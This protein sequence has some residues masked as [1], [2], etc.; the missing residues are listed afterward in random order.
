MTDVLIY[1]EI[2][3]EV[4]ASGV[5]DQLK[6]AA[7]EPVTVRISSGG[8]DVYEGIAIMNALRGYEGAV[9]VVIESLAASAASFIAAGCGGRVVARPNAE[10]MVHRA[11]TMQMGNSDDL[12]KTIGDLERQDTKLAAIYADKSGGGAE[13]WLDRMAAETWFT[14]QEAMDAGLV[15]AV[16]DAKPMAPA[17][18]MQK[19][20][21]LASC[22]YGS[23]SAAPPPPI[24]PRSESRSTI[25]TTPSDGQNGA[26]MSILN[27]LAQDLG[28][29]PAEVQSALAGLFRNEVVPISGEVNVTYPAD[30]KIIPTQTIKIEPIVGDKPAEGADGSVEVVPEGEA[31]AEPAGDSAAVQLAKSAGLAFAMGDIAEGWTAEVDEGGI[32]TVKAPSGAEV[33]ASADFTVLVNETSVALAVT[34]RSFDEDTPPAPDENPAPPAAPADT[35]AAVADTVTVP[36]AHFDYLNSVVKNFGQAQAKLTAQENAQRVDRDIAEGRFVAAHRAQA[37]SALEHSP[38][39]Y[40]KVWGSLPKNTIP[41]A[42]IGS[43]KNPD[44]SSPSANHSDLREKAD[45]FGFLSRK[46]FH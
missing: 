39:D 23:R 5:V 6:A 19:S 4:T 37:L 35:G 11:W 46:N 45:K 10:V 18:S 22:R 31:P 20:R 44:E 24:A 17:A 42:E 3:W 38:Q 29:S 14:A 32:V 9:T 16:E 36:R 41:V 26:R 40:E 28:K 13:E 25:T 15:D 12:T 21:V 2:G 43:G 1:G 33:G 27:Q 7:G 8:G 34:V 30:V